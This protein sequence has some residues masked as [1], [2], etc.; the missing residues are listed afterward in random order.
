[1]TLA[2]LIPV[3]PFAAFGLIVFFGRR[4]PGQGA[5]VA[6]GAM[7]GAALISLVIF[8]QLAAGADEFHQAFTWGTLGEVPLNIGIQVDQLTAVM[9]LVV[10]IVGS[11][12]FV[13]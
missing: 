12:I 7:L 5:Y 9:L 3:L 10:T 1:M 11:L 13:Y 4:L 6:I 8:F 2:W